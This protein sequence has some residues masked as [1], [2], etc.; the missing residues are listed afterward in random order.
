MANMSKTIA[1]QII[2]IADEGSEILSKLRTGQITFLE[3]ADRIRQATRTL[4]AIM[5]SYHPDT[6]KDPEIEAALDKVREVKRQ[7]LK[8]AID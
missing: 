1:E 2:Q 5:A 3:A 8:F 7:L 6:N 4:K